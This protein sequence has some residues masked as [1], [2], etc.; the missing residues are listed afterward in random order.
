MIDRTFCVERGGVWGCP[1]CDVGGSDG[2]R[3]ER[4]DLFWF[5]IHR[6]CAMEVWEYP[7]DL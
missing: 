4:S 1:I 6:Q 2:E 5:W 7:V 3:D